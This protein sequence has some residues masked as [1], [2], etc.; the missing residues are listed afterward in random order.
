MSPAKHDKKLLIRVTIM[1]VLL[2]IAL[3][4]IPVVT[5][6]RDGRPFFGNFSGI[7]DGAWSFE[8][9]EIT[10]PV[11]RK[12]GPPWRRI[13]VG[14]TRSQVEVD[15]K[16]RRLLY[17]VFRDHSRPG[18]IG[19][20]PEDQT[21][22]PNAGFNYYHVGGVWRYIEFEFDEN[23]IVTRIHVGNRY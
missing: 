22:L 3:E 20:W 6:F 23:D 7:S 10:D 8:P 19:I 9:L 14:S 13:G 5:I 1:V 17:S 2:S 4:M 16:I 15:F 12:S 21:T 11:H 18:G